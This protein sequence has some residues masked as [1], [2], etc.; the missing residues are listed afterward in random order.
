MA[1]RDIQDQGR[2]A[3]LPK[4][5]GTPVDNLAFFRT[6]DEMVKEH[7]SLVCLHSAYRYAMARLIES[8][9]DPKS[10]KSNMDTLLVA[11]ATKFAHF[12]DPD[13]N[14]V[15]IWEEIIWI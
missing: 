2:H 6:F 9:G 7:T 13:G 1:K 3:G 5:V 8:V 4:V 11:S 14:E 15:T 10:V 12:H